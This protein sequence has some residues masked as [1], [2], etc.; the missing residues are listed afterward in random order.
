MNLKTARLPWRQT[1]RNRFIF[2]HTR[3]SNVAFWL[4]QD[5]DAL[6]SPD[7]GLEEGSNYNRHR[8]RFILLGLSF[9]QYMQEITSFIRLTA[10]VF[11]KRILYST[12][13]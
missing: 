9:I 12:V 8:K 1:N 2:V 13:P 5:I 10:K 4:S 6:Q 11:H 3:L 7:G